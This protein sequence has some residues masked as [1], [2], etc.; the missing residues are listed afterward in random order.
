MVKLNRNEI[1]KLIKE[2]TGNVISD[3]RLLSGMSYSSKM[4]DINELFDRGGVSS[5]SFI[6]LSNFP[7][8]TVIQASSQKQLDML[9]PKSKLQIQSIHLSNDIP[10]GWDGDFD[11]ESNRIMDRVINLED[12]K[13]INSVETHFYLN[14]DL[15]K[16][17]MPDSVSS[18]KF[19]HSKLPALQIDDVDNIEHIEINHS[20][21]NNIENSEKLE[22]TASIING[23]FEDPEDYYEED[24][25][26][27]DE[28]EQNVT[29]DNKYE[30][31]LHGETVLLGDAPFEISEKDD[32]GIYVT[33]MNSENKPF[34]EIFINKE[35]YLI[36]GDELYSISKNSNGGIGRYLDSVTLT[37][38][39]SGDIIHSYAYTTWNGENMGGTVD[40]RRGIFELRGRRDVGRGYTPTE[41]SLFLVRDGRIVP[42]SIVLEEGSFEDCGNNLYKAFMQKIKENKIELTPKEKGYKNELLCDYAKIQANSKW[43]D[44]YNFDADMF[45]IVKDVVTPNLRVDFINR[46]IKQNPELIKF[47]PEMLNSGDFTIK[48]VLS[49]KNSTKQEEI[50]RHIAKEVFEGKITSKE[51]LNHAIYDKDA[52]ISNLPFLVRLSIKNGENLSEENNIYGAVFNKAYPSLSNG[53]Q[54]DGASLY[55]TVKTLLDNGIPINQ[56]TFNDGYSSTRLIT[57]LGDYKTSELHYIIRDPAARLVCKLGDISNSKNGKELYGQLLDNIKSLEDKQSLLLSELISSPEGEISAKAKILSEKVSFEN[58]S[59]KDAISQHRIDVCKYL[60]NKGAK[61]TE[62]D[63]SNLRAHA[64]GAFL[65]TPVEQSAAASF[66]KIVTNKTRD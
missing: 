28:F 19:Q 21:M 64:R 60:F 66:I 55:S 15:E 14:T 8:V 61:A 34:N 53:Y 24:Y 12:Y 47:V 13:N 58:I 6:D 62:A 27:A 31:K 29:D 59:M 17:E 51:L 37:N 20:L 4:L 35:K 49:F 36:S 57:V 56:T 2:E 38:T 26:L 11:M 39:K 40:M 23:F 25:S 16:I 65:D 7:D 50:M 44:L 10:V 22:I 45:E 52:D 42:E 9:L 5:A 30:L 33:Y 54:F 1:E 41:T 3:D 63:I 46:N 18:L 48:N 43:G 32:N